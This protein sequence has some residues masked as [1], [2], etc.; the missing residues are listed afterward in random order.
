M[1]TNVSL[2][3]LGFPYILKNTNALS[4]TVKNN[5]LYIDGGTQTFVPVVGGVQQ[6]N[7]ITI[8][9]SASL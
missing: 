4:A 1:I 7:N 2:S 8:G 9:Y 3:V 5:K 6:T